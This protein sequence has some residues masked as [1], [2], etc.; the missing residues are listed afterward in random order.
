MLIII[1]LLIII[2]WQRG[3]VQLQ[4]LLVPCEKPKIF[5]FRQ[6]EFSKNPTHPRLRFSW[7]LA[8]MPFLIEGTFPPCECNVLLKAANCRR[9]A[10]KAFRPTLVS[11]A[12][13]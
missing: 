2:F 13:V 10:L 4:P 7:L 3:F 6:A 5:G 12:E 1:G 9:Y 11:L 8:Q